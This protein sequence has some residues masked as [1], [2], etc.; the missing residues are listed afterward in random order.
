[1]LPRLI[2]GSGKPKTTCCS[3]KTVWKGGKSWVCLQEGTSK[4]RVSW[5]GSAASHHR[6]RESPNHRPPRRR[7]LHVPLPRPSL[8]PAARVAPARVCV[9][10]WVGERG[11]AAATER[12]ASW[13]ER[14]FLTVTRCRD[15][16]LGFPFDLPVNDS[17]LPPGTKQLFRGGDQRE[18]SR[19]P[20][21]PCAAIA[22]NG[23]SC[24]VHQT[25]PVS[26]CE[27]TPPPPFSFFCGSKSF[28]Y[29]RPTEMH[30]MLHVSTVTSAPTPPNWRL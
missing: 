24:S 8:N 21:P 25:Q 28:R 9:C 12:R 23:G 19:G 7:I 18:I 20:R 10:V 13:F 3:G 15:S 30:Q 26:R 6:N 11:A 5:L 27:T 4:V 29:L 1:M 17:R 14:H 22:L 16:S 2:V